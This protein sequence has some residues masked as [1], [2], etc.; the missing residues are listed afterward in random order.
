MTVSSVLPSGSRGLAQQVK[1]E[2]TIRD[3]LR[4]RGVQALVRVVTAADPFEG[5]LR[6]V[7]TYGLGPLVPNT[8]VLGDSE[9]PSRREQYC[10]A[11]AQIY[12][13]NRNLVI[14]R[15]NRQLGL[16]FRRRIDVW[17]G[18]KQNNGSLM[19][20]LA[21]LLRTDINWRNADIYLKLVVNDN[22]A[23][24]AA[25]NNL[26]NFVSKLRIDVI[27]QVIVAKGRSFA[28]ILRQSSSD[29][30]LIFLGMAKP[31][32]N[33]TDYY[34]SLQMRVADLPSTIF[35]LAAPNFAFGEV[36]SES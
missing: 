36:L 19:L 13:S 26:Q 10:Q 3:Y 7:E 33:F 21:Y 11:I 35:V 6:L 30:N 24:V 31:Q 27:S 2:K 18:G 22:D 23:A 34:E 32:E 8:I 9:E 17:W 5:A 1:L 4:K 15:E 16:G 28:E 29:A 25:S 20:L 12:S 14:F